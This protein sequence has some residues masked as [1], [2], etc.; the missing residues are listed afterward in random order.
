MAES[1]SDAEEMPK[2]RGRPRIGTN[3]KRKRAKA[4][5]PSLPDIDDLEELEERP[6]PVCAN[7]DHTSSHQF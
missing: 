3:T 5:T 2:Q 6:A 7:F 4:D 1:D